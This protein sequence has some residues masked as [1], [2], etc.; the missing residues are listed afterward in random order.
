MP[1]SFTTPPRDVEPAPSLDRPV[2]NYRMKLLTA[3]NSMPP[4]PTI[5]NQLLGMLNNDLASAGQVAQIIERDSVLSGSVLRCVNSA[6]YAL[7]GRVSSIRQAVTLLGFPTVRNLALA[8]S[9]RRMM[10]GA[11]PSMKIYSSYSKH[12]LGCAVMSQF[13]AL[14]TRAGDL[15]AA[16]AGGLFHDVGKLLVLTT[17]PE[18]VPQ[19]I[20]RWEKGGVSYVDAEAEILEVT[21]PELSAVVLETWKL[22]EAIRDAARFH[23]EPESYPAPADAEGPTLASIV[24]AANLAVNHL[25]HVTIESTRERETPDAAFEALGLADEQQNLIEKFQAEFANLGAAFG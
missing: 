2:V 5:L 14:Y 9:M 12:A 19:V 6:F 24:H 25:G 13:L 10:V 15:D 4:L 11:Q 18:V 21:H 17:A 1:R 22:P 20:E 7:P 8:F 3:V 23:H 16:F